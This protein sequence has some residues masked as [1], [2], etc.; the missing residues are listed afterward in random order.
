[1]KFSKLIFALLISVMLFTAFCETEAQKTVYTNSGNS[2]Y[3]KT[4]VDTF[5]VP[6]VKYSLR[7]GF[8][9]NQSATKQLLVY[10]SDESGAKDTSSRVLIEPGKTLHFTFSGTKI[11]RNAVTDSAYSQVIIGDVQLNYAPGFEQNNNIAVIES[12]AVLNRRLKLPA[13]GQLPE[14]IN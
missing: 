9:S 2:K 5:R 7:K 4:A 12:F 1:M 14:F 11:F 13:P 10:F 6:G 8:I 3:V